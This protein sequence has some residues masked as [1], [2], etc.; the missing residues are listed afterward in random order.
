MNDKLFDALRNHQRLRELAGEKSY[1]RGEGY[2]TGGAVRSLVTHAGRLGARVE[3]TEDYTVALWMEAGEINFSCSCP[4]GDG[5]A[6]CKHCVAV[7]LCYVAVVTTPASDEDEDDDYE[8]YSAK[9][10]LRT[11]DDVQAFLATKRKEH[12]VELLMQVAFESD[13]WR[14]HLKRLAH[15]G[16]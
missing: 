4:M 10:K 1:A 11:L 7:A 15:Q 8:F 13:E 6:F 16:I 14:A 9:P 12:L 3:G 5:G 2:F